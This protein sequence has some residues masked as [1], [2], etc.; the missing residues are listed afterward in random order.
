MTSRSFFLQDAMVYLKKKKIDSL[1]SIT[2]YYRFLVKFLEIFVLLFSQTIN[3]S[4]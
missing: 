2:Q 1:L 4:A 3:A